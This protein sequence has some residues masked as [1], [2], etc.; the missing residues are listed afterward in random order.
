MKLLEERFRVACTSH[1]CD[2][3]KGEIKQNERYSY[4][5]DKIN[6]DKFEAKLH[7]SCL[8]LIDIEKQFLS[9]GLYLLN[10]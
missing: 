8:G 7:K 9:K 6:N 5:S 10:T 2:Y 1:Q 3:C 4:F